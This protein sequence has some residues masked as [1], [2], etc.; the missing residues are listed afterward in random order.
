MTAVLI[1]VILIN[2]LL[3]ML[4]TNA[5]IQIKQLRCVS[6]SGLVAQV[7]IYTL[8]ALRINWFLK[9]RQ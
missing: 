8:S 4:L 9:D 5:Q 6:D 7:K 1:I 3:S 2:V